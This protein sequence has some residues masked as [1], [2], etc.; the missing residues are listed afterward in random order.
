MLNGMLNN[1]ENNKNKDEGKK[2]TKPVRD[3]KIE[4]IEREVDK[5]DFDGYEVVMREFFLKRKYSC[6]Y[7][8]VRRHQF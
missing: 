4:F 5:F 1:N 8:K 2:F 3:G 6:D 7:D